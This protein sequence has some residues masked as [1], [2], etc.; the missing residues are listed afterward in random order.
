MTKI[1]NSKPERLS[2]SWT[3]DEANNWEDALLKAFDLLMCGDTLPPVDK[4]VDLGRK[5]SQYVDN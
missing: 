2:V 1:R 5:N 4:P 3:K